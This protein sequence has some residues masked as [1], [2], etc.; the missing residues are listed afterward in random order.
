MTSEE[1]QALAALTGG[2]VIGRAVYVLQ[3]DS[4]NP[5]DA[6]C[7]G[8]AFSTKEG[9]FPT[10]GTLEYRRCVQVGECFGYVAVKV[11]V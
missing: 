3:P 4:P 1:L 11:N 7:F 9:Y 5:D 2:R 6:R 10:P 8:C